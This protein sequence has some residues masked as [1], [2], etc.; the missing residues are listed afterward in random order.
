MANRSLKVR[1]ESVS[2]TSP[3]NDGLETQES[4]R[5]TTKEGPR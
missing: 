5:P 4:V 2:S 3:T 1:A